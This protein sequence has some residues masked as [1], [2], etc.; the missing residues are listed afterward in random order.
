MKLRKH[1]LQ[2]PSRIIIDS[3]WIIME[4]DKNLA[5]IELRKCGAHNES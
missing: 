2:L 4:I 1:E 5:E 3:V